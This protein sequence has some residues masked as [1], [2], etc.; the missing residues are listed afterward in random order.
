MLRCGPYRRDG[1]FLT[2]HAF[3]PRSSNRH[4]LETPQIRRIHKCSTSQI[5]PFPFADGLFHT[6]TVA[7]WD[8][9]SLVVSSQ[10]VLQSKCKINLWTNRPATVKRPH[11]TQHHGMSVSTTNQKNG[12]VACFE[13]GNRP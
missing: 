10:P 4:R 6:S 7:N 11:A 8:A 13:T 12:F 3:L 5:Q 9:D 2:R 1:L